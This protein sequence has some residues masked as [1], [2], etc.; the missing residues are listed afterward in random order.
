LT[1]GARQSAIDITVQAWNEAIG[2]LYTASS[3][4][5]PNELAEN[6]IVLV[7][8]DRDYVLQTDLNQL[9][10]P[11]LDETFGHRIFEWE[12]GYDNLVARQLQPATWEGLPLF[13]VIRPTDGELY[14]DRLPTVSE[15]GRT[16]KY[17]YDKDLELTAA[18]DVMPFKDAVFRALVPAVAQL[19]KRDF[20]NEFD[21]AIFG[22]RIG[23]A[24]KYLTQKQ[25][26][27][28]WLPN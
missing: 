18:A 27:K 12:K 7:A 21:E 16:Y 6:T 3:L 14:L 20:R 15:A 22:E 5:Q 24:S 2:S 28:S 8:A 13:A 9:R 1:D 26:R 25:M 10:F 17:R 11:L 4:P 19:W 23:E